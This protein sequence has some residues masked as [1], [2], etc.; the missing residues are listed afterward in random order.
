MLVMARLFSIDLK[1]FKLEYS[2][3]QGLNVGVSEESSR[4]RSL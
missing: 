2:Y 3:N 1:R 4:G